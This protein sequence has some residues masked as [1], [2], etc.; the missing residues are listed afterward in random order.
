MRPLTFVAAPADELADVRAQIARLRSREVA[1]SAQL[2]LTPLAPLRS[3]RPGWP[4]QRQMP[5]ETPHTR[6]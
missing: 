3:P 6:H 2:L 1:L 4:I 5:A